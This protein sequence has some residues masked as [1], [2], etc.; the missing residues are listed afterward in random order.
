MCVCSECDGGDDGSDSLSTGA[1]VGITVAL[2]L[3]VALP[4]GV[5]IGVGVSWWVGRSRPREGKQLQSLQG[6]SDAL[7]EEPVPL[8]TSSVVGG[9]IPLSHN[10][11]YGQVDMQ[12]RTMEN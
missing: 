5:V 1:A 4:G 10:Q 12:R 9:D 3:L 6:A 11:A 7:Y 8:A 2:T